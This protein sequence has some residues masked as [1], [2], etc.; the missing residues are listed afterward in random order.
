MC[1]S[2]SQSRL[3]VK[4]RIKMPQPIPSYS[5]ILKTH[6]GVISPNQKRPMN[7]SKTIIGKDPALKSLLRSVKIVAPTDATVLIT[8]ETGT[9]KELIAAAIFKHSRRSDKEFIPLN[10][11]ALPESLIESE[12]FGYCKGA[13]TGATADKKGILACSPRR[14]PVFR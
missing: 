12:L 13:F 8:G 9:G 2:C 1:L 3:Q 7:L 4:R 11:A 5:G 14:N 6:N 10:C